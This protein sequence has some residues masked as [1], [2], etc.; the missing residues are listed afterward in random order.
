MP[1]RV[2]EMLSQGMGKAKAIKARLSGLVGVFATLSEQHG[3]ASAL[4]KRVK[5]HPA[6]RAELWPTLR[7]ELLSH[8]RGEMRVVYPEL[9]AHVETRALAEQHDEEAGEMEQTVFDLDATDMNSEAWEAKLGELIRMVENHVHEEESNIFPRAQETLGEEMARAMEK[10][11]L[12]AQA[13]V[14]RAA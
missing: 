3:E 7:R 14:K 5:G 9:R 4:L 11:F 12:D 1:N 6:K 8:E 13:E 10:R 2:D